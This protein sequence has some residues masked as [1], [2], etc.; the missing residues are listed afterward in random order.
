MKDTFVNESTVLSKDNAALKVNCG[1]LTER[2]K[3]LEDVKKQLKSSVDADELDVDVVFLPKA[4]L[5][6]LMNDVIE[7]GE[8]IWQSI[9]KRMLVIMQKLYQMFQIKDESESEANLKVLTKELKS[10]IA[11]LKNRV[12][13]ETLNSEILKAQVQELKDKLEG[14]PVFTHQ[15][16]GPAGDIIDYESKFKTLLKF[17]GKHKNVFTQ[18]SSLSEC[19]EWQD[20]QQMLLDNAT[21]LNLSNPLFSVEPEKLDGGV[22]TENWAIVPIGEVQT[23]VQEENVIPN[24][25]FTEVNVIDTQTDVSAEDV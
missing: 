11:V 9:Q 5:T 19:E 2:L 15:T 3:V 24:V 17:V 21:D 13:V 6:N 20:V 22:L 25:Q 8:Q 4:D 16:Q 1:V 12:A 18:I 10:T 7:T 14:K 23:F